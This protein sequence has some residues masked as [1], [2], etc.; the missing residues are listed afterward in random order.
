M[1][2]FLGIY[3]LDAQWIIH[4]MR[5]YGQFQRW[6]QSWIKEDKPLL[7]T[8]ASTAPESASLP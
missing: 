1:H 7:L 2:V 5:K 4:G 3:L 8:V 6:V